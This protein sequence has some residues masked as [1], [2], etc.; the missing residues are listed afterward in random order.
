ML[1][2][3]ATCIGAKYNVK[4]FL[5]DPHLLGLPRV[6]NESGFTVYVAVVLLQTSMQVW[7]CHFFTYC[8]KYR[9]CLTS[10]VKPFRIIRQCNLH[11]IIAL[12]SCFSMNA[13][14]LLSH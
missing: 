2:S 8:T 11:N 7:L 5:V 10:L 3:Q 14:L 9:N 6:L 1:L 4:T 12:K 13:R